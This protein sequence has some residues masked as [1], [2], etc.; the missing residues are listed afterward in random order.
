VRHRHMPR[1]HRRRPHHMSIQHHGFRRT[2]PRRLLGF[3]CSIRAAL[4]PST[5]PPHLTRHRPPITVSHS[6]DPA[7]LSRQGR[8][9]G[10][11]GGSTRGRR[12]S[13]GATAPSHYTGRQTASV[14]HRRSQASPRRRPSEL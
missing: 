5:R 8:S 10:A 2:H 3:Q 14:R 4:D 7:H 1:P 6:M 13:T 11:P 12:G 9:P